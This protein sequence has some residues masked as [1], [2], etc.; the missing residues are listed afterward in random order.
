MIQFCSVFVCLGVPFG[1]G[2][3]LVRMLSSQ[4]SAATSWP[5]KT[6]RGHSQKRLVV[7][8][9]CFYSSFPNSCFFLLSSV[10]SFIYQVPEEGR[11]LITLAASPS[12]RAVARSP[13]ADPRQHLL[14]L[15][16]ALQQ[17]AVS[18]GM[19]LCRLSH[20]QTSKC[21]HSFS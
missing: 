5:F 13:G 14:L 7:R 15:R 12:V 6:L 16:V 8:Y 3:L 11:R 20:G 17:V 1:P 21:T 9:R 4:F 2:V 10:F 18:P 19:G